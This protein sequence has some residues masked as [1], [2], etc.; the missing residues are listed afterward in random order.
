MN[1]ATIS[2]QSGW[3]D[4]MAEHSASCSRHHPVHDISDAEM[5]RFRQVLAKISYRDWSVRVLDFDG[6]AVIQLY[7]IVPDS[8]TGE[9]IENNGRPLALCPEM[10][11]GFLL[12]LAFELIKEFELHETAE[13][14]KMDGAR[15]YLPH[16]ASGA[17]LFEVASMRARSPDH[18]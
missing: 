13:R 8:T 5:D 10:S 1:P 16:N 9:P 7:T 15:V 2:L 14:F 17:P 11:D 18:Q 3:N 4:M 6:A 12:D